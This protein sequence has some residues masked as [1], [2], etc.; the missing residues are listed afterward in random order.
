A[1]AAG[2]VYGMAYGDQPALI[3]ELVDWARACGFEVICA[4]KGMNFE[5]HFRYSTPDTVWDH[6]GFTEEQ[7]RHG[8]FNPQMFN[9]FVDGTK[10]AIEMAAVANGTGL[11]CMPRGLDFPPCGVHDL[12]QVLKPRAE[13][14][15]LAHAGMVEIAASQEPDGREVFNN[16]RF[17]VFVTFRAPDEY[18]RQC[19]AQYGLKTDRSGWYASLWRPFHLIGLE[20][21][22]SV[23]NAALRGEPTGS[24]RFWQGDAVATAKRDLKAGEVLDGEGGYLL[25]GRLMRAADSLDRGA[26]PIGL[27]HGVRLRHPVAKDQPVRWS[28][29]EIDETLEA[30]RVRREMERRLGE[31]A[32]EAAD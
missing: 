14:G 16:V 1:R 5:P 13:G 19:F 21:G 7:V 26:L 8:D 4:G 30:V 17:G 11:T 15:R 29:V 3:C 32:A 25:W 24:S 9:S 2:V 27:A 22:I 10:S 28:D 31:L 12:A 18:S 20:T 23:A 6:F